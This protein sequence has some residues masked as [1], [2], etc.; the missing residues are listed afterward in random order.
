MVTVFNP[1]TQKRKRVC[2]FF[3]CGSTG[4]FISTELARALKLPNLGSESLRLDTFA[5]DKPVRLDTFRTTLGF[6]QT[7][8]SCLVLDLK[9]SHRLV[10]PLEAIFIEPSDEALLKQNHCNL[11]PYA[12]VPDILIG[13]DKEHLFCKE[14]D[15][16]LPSGFTLLHTTTGTILSGHG[17]FRQRSA[18]LTCSPKGSADPTCPPRHHQVSAETPSCGSADPSVGRSTTE[19]RAEATHLSVFYTRA[20]PTSPAAMAQR[21]D[22]ACVWNQIAVVPLEECRIRRLDKDRFERRH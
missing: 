2:A 20:H 22:R 21:F 14:Y 12:V 18:D 13:K 5:Q 8:G 3:D 9:A 15:P 10:P 4:T 16:P 11:V 7:D 6:D 1:I 19:A 17:Q